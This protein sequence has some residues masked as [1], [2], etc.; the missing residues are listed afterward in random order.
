MFVGVMFLPDEVTMISLVRP[1]IVRK[2]S[3][4]IVPRSPVLNQPS[5]LRTSLVSSSSPW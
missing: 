4:S 3:S 2:P 1:A 5:S